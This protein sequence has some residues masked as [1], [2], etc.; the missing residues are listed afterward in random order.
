MLEKTLD[1]L[2][3]TVESDKPA[4]S[5][6]TFDSAHQ[7][8]LPSETRKLFLSR[9]AVSCSPSSRSMSPESLTALDDYIFGVGPRRSGKRT[10]GAGV[11]F[12]PQRKGMKRKCII[13]RQPLRKAERT[14]L[15]VE[16]AKATWILWDGRFWLRWSSPTGSDRLV[17]KA[18]GLY[19]LPT[20]VDCPGEVIWTMSESHGSFGKQLVTHNMRT[21]T[22]EWRRKVT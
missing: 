17:V 22:V 21:I 6:L 15:E 18:C 4:P 2:L 9:L 12:A 16:L 7:R 20:L 11:I 5:T 19:V 14:S 13:Y 8:H 3:T 1:V 10:P